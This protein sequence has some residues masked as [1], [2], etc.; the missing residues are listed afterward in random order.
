[1][2]GEFTHGGGGLVLEGGAKALFEHEGE[3]WEWAVHAPRQGGMQVKLLQDV[4][5]Y[6]AGDLCSVHEV[7]PEGLVLQGGK[8]LSRCWEGQSWKWAAGKPSDWHHFVGIGDLTVTIL[9]QS[10]D[11]FP[12]G[13]VCNVIGAEEDG[14]VLEGGL[15]AP[16]AQ[17]GVWWTWTDQQPDVW[18]SPGKE[19]LV[20]R[21]TSVELSQECLAA[22]PIGS[23][24][25]LVHNFR[26]LVKGEVY[27]VLE[28]LKN[29][30]RFVLE[31]G[32]TIRV[33]T[34]GVSWE[35]VEDRPRAEATE[36]GGGDLV[37]RAIRVLRHGWG[38]FDKG[39]VLTVTGEFTHGQGGGGGGLVLERGAM[40]QFGQ[41]GEVWEWAV[42]APGHGGMQIKLLQDICGYAAGDLCSVHEVGP[43]G[44]VLQGGKKLQRCSEDRVWEWAAG[45]PSDWHSFVGL[46]DVTV[47]IL[48]QSWD[49]FPVGK[50]CNVIGAEEDG[51]V[52]EGGLFAPWAQEGVWWTWAD[53]Q[54]DIWTFVGKE[55]LVSRSTSVELS[56]ECLAADPIGSVRI[57]V[58]NFRN[59]VKGEVYRVLRKENRPKFFVLEDGNII[60]QSLEGVLWEW[61]EDGPSTPRST[62]MQGLALSSRPAPPPGTPQVTIIQHQWRG[63]PTGSV[64]AVVD[65]HADG[66]L[67]EGG[68][69][70]S[71]QDE[72][73]VW[74]WAD[75]TQPELLPKPVPS[76][77]D[78]GLADGGRANAEGEAPNMI[79]STSERRWE[80]S[81]D[82]TVRIVAGGWGGYAK[83]TVCDVLSVSVGQ[84]GPKLSVKGGATGCAKSAL[85]L[86]EGQSWE[87]A[88][89]KPSNWREFCDGNPGLQVRLL[90]DW[91]GSVAGAL[92]D[93]LVV[94]ARG[95]R[96]KGGK[97]ALSHEEGSVWEWAAGRPSDWPPQAPAADGTE[98][99]AVG[100]DEGVAARAPEGD[101]RGAAVRILRNGWGGFARGTLCSVSG[102]WDDG[103]PQAGLVL[104]GGKRT[105]L[106]QE[107]S[108]WEWA[109]A[110]PPSVSTAE[111]TETTW[112]A[113]DGA[114]SMG[115]L[116]D[117]SDDALSDTSAEDV[118][119]DPSQDVTQIPVLY[120]T[121]P[122]EARHALAQLYAEKD[123]S[124]ACA[125]D[126]EGVNL[127]ATGR[128]TSTPVTPPH[129]PCLSCGACP[130]PWHLPSP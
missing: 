35:W 25:I 33:S 34:K 24:R 36:G 96:L 59:L 48:Q 110:V 30:R 109:A 15:F 22:D 86:S 99:V 53:Q 125:V 71:L 49:G 14:A 3:V 129:V 29:P 112:D 12:V 27:R 120:I 6:A 57:L 50:V 106:S 56:Q 45:K 104:E 128:C 72:G 20:S 38:G 67:L 117:F 7:G 58:L 123:P 40:T 21:S 88:D 54:P 113:S 105:K 85:A 65:R 97:T 74:E 28:K 94:D 55:E 52:L 68:V 79:V 122:E 90:R 60:R 4:C 11:G 37:G 81:G 93:V 18:R 16:W 114:R 44:L 19:E 78:R 101:L 107:G 89:G 43:D 62:A 92:C 47:T 66:L 100:K 124:A 51:A 126:C 8:K 23:V 84:R 17:E 116:L 82:A 39:D 75:G 61:V 46:D 87:W 70:A 83:G 103:G 108:V 26:N 77:A 5:G 1:M 76:A 91:G 69:C 73:S 102:Q 2:T 115:K 63:L 127:S 31:D 118:P 13:K 111:A 42:D 41:E 130:C 121:S 9:Q 95:L 119:V 80:L 64:H 98:A 32:N 10:W